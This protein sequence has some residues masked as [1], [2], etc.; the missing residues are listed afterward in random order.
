[1]KNRNN[2]IT[3]Q[4]IDNVLEF[5]SLF[6]GDTS[7]LY[8]DHTDAMR[9]GEDDDLIVDVDL[10]DDF[11][12]KFM[13]FWNALRE[14]HFLIPVNVKEVGS[15]NIDV[16][17]ADLR[18]MSR[19][20]SYHSRGQKFCTGYWRGL[21]DSGFFLMFL[22]R[23]KYIKEEMLFKGDM[24]GKIVDLDKLSEEMEKDQEI[25]RK[26]ENEEP[27]RRTI[28]LDKLNQKMEEPM[29]KDKKRNDLN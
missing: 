16:E 5:L 13:E 7:E 25:K 20:I 4:N 14:N 6:E 2:K 27:R 21:I 24:Y 19:L 9:K 3:I 23:L 12:P 29:R 28:D 18:A 1:M 17:K 15:E 8:I 10:I 26:H 11:T 22:K